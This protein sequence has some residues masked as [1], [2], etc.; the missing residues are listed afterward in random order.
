MPAAAR[1]TERAAGVG[2]DDGVVRVWG[3]VQDDGSRGGASAGGLGSGGAGQ[4][5]HAQSFDYSS[6][7]SLDGGEQM[8]MRTFSF[9]SMDGGSLHGFD[10]AARRGLVVGTR[11]HVSFDI[12]SSFNP[13]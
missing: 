8:G 12:A 5:G 10:G 1:S 13:R 4:R 2:S 6:H 7:G 9:D 3:G 11:R